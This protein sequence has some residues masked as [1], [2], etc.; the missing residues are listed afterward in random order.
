[1]TVSYRVQVPNGPLWK[2]PLAESKGVHREV[3]SEGS[4][5]QKMEPTNRNW[6]QG[7]TCRVT[8]HWT[9]KPKIHT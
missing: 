5:R 3:K 1:M 8:G 2:E 4:S 9:G 6:I 7:V